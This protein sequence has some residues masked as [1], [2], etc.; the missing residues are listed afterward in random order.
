MSADRPD[1]PL[2]GVL[3]DYGQRLTAARTHA[4][5]EGHPTDARTILDS[6]DRTLHPWLHGRR[7]V[8]LAA[9][10]RE[11]WGGSQ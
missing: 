11:W 6:Y 7:P 5:A 2:S 3:Y 1:G 9:R 4:V 10:L 8:D